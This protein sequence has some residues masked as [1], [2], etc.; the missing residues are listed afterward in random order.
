LPSPCDA[1]QA[2]SP[3]PT[4]SQT[5]MY[6]MRSPPHEIALERGADQER[7]TCLLVLRRLYVSRFAQ[8]WN[9]YLRR[10]DLYSLL[11]QRHARFEEYRC[12]QSQCHANVMS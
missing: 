5:D 7:R 3:A 9:G 11:V 10:I 6:P 4:W 1:L 8:S 2:I 12:N